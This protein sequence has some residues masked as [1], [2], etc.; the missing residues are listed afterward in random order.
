MFPAEEMNKQPKMSRTMENLFSAAESRM[1]ASERD[2]Q[3]SK[4]TMEAEGNEDKK[5]KKA[6]KLSMRMLL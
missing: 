5:L 4:S 2:L 6:I 3:S 1:E